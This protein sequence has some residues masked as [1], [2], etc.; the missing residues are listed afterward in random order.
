MPD[1]QI[2]S[3]SDVPRGIVAAEQAGAIGVARLTPLAERVIQALGSDANPLIAAL[4]N[5]AERQTFIQL[6]V[7][8]QKRSA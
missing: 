4:N 5:L 1:L 2:N 3:W 7:E 6:L 8:R